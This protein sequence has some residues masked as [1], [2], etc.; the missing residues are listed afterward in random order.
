MVS[1]W[2]G[3]KSVLYKSCKCKVLGDSCFVSWVFPC[4]PMQPFGAP[5][6]LTLLW[7]VQ[8]RLLNI[9]IQSCCDTI[10]F[11]YDIM[12]VL[13]RMIVTSFGS[14]YSRNG[15]QCRF[16]FITSFFLSA[17]FLTPGRQASLVPQGMEMRYGGPFA[18][19]WKFL[20]PEIFWCWWTWKIKIW[21]TL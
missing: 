13:W 3:L 19:S 17:I 12:F 1:W 6:P 21:K 7:F 10:L 4:S 8:Q 2:E 11:I 5:G 9:L 16:E 20:L 14:E 18:P 15:C